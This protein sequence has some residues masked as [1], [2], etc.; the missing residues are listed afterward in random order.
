MGNYA[1]TKSIAN[2]TDRVAEIRAFGLI[3]FAKIC[4]LG[5][6]SAVQK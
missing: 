5:V 6:F 1:V 3:F 2:A 4:R